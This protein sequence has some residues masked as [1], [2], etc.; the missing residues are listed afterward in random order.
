[1]NNQRCPQCDG[2][3]IPDPIE[4]DDAIASRFAVGG[5]LAQRDAYVARARFK[6]AEHGRLYRCTGCGY[7]TR[8]PRQPPVPAS[9]RTGDTPRE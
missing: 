4:S 1:M 5:N 7:Q 8:V 2:A 6:I 9:R 3:L